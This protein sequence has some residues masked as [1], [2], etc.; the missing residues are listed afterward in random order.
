MTE[1]SNIKIMIVEDNPGMLTIMSAIL[2]GLGFPNQ[3][4]A[5]DGDAAFKLMPQY[6]PD[7]IITDIRMPKAGGLQFI[8][9][10]RSDL[11]DPINTTQILVVTAHATQTDV[12][13]CLASGID[14]FLAKPFTPRSLAQR[15]NAL[16]SEKREFVRE[17]GYFGPR[18]HA[19]SA[20]IQL[21]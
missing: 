3:K 1:F 4:F 10:V 9:S 14:H 7:L 8:R 12:R 13:S 21:Q 16:I 11:R 17:P 18:R 19:P 20:S 2:R 5:E 6:G 15:L